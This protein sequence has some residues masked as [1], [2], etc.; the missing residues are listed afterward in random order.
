M[1]LLGAKQSSP[2]SRRTFIAGLA[3]IAATKSALADD[4][5]SSP[6]AH[7]VL[8]QN[9]LALAFESAPPDLPDVVLIGPDGGRNISQLKGRT[10]LMPLWAEWCGPCLGEIPDFARL[11]QKYGNSRFAIVPV[12][13]GAQKKMTPAAIAQ[14]FNYLHASVFEPL[15]ENNF[16]NVLMIAMTEKHRHYTEI[17]C[18]LLIAPDGHV[19]GREF[20]LKSNGT[21]A[22]P[23]GVT[24]AAAKSAM[25]AQAEAGNSLSLWGKD[26]GDQFAQAMANGFLG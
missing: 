1:Q 26:A 17:P 25:I 7:G 13:T 5:T 9:P 10:L 22:A 24:G 3:S 8:A 2:V 18:N 11:Q 23:D 12:L 6:V 16:G 4:T 14:V 20:G 19:V 21:A 15:V